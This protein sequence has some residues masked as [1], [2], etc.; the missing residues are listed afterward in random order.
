MPR[1]G[2]YRDLMAQAPVELRVAGHSYRV[3]TSAEE[4]EL[5]ALARIVEAKLREV[6]PP[7]RA[8]SQQSLLLAALALAHELTEER[9]R[10][11]RIEQRSREML[12]SLLER[13]D[14]AL[15][16]DAVSAADLDDPHP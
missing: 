4:E 8:P 3:N 12:Q 7:G 11:E 9:A 6:T 13:I 1:R 15:G 16:H 5:R 14:D 2:C 10:R